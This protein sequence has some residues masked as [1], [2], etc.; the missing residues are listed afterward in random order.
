MNP[1]DLSTPEGRA[2][3]QAELRAVGRGWRVVGIGLVLTAVLWMLIAKG[4]GR[5]LDDPMFQGSL[6]LLAAG[7]ALVIAGVVRRS[8]HH[9]RRLRG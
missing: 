4:L 1:P 7:W 6:L 5:A 3:Y 8:L 9:R 2:A